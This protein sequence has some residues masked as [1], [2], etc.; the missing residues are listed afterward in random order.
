VSEWHGYLA[1]FFDGE[2]SVTIARVRANGL[3]DYHKIVVAVGQRAKYR[4][5]LDRIQAEFGGYVMLRQQESRVRHLW[6]EHAVWQLQD[7]RGIERFLAAI[8]PHSMVKREQIRI[9]LEFVQTFTAAARARDS[10]GR[11][12]GKVLTSEEIERR[13]RLRLELRAANELGPPK[14]KPSILP[15]LDVQLRRP[16]ELIADPTTVRRGVDRYN[17]RFTEDDIRSIRD[18][19]ESKGATQEALAAQYGVSLMTI[20]KIVNRKTWRHVT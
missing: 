14:A 8:Q 17:A 18:V 12:R 3:S 4:E 2:G 5:V 9:G 1:G 6:A 7:K 16:S 20:N 15:P 10:L 11:I 19:Y 13:E